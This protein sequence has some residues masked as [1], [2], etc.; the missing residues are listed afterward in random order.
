MGITLVPFIASDREGREVT[1]SG[2]HVVAEAKP[3]DEL[4]DGYLQSTSGIQLAG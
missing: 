2:A 3:N 1:I 4:R